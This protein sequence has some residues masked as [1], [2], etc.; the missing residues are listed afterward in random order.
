MAASPVC[1]DM[2]DYIVPLQTL[3]EQ[4]RRLPGVGSKTA[5]RYAMAV[6]KLGEEDVANFADAILGAKRDVHHCKTCF[7]ISEDDICPICADPDRDPTTI[8]VVEDIQDV[9]AVERVRNYRGLYH[10]LGGV[11]NPRRQISG[12][13]LHIAELLDRVETGGVSEVILATNPTFEG[14]TTAHYL[15]KLLGKYEGLRVTRLAYGIP[16]GGDLEY[17]DEITLERAMQ[18][19]NSLK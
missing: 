7:N 3:I 10:V 11:L 2:A 18:G 1:S 5:V 19:R 14:D 4:F 17:A 13:H 8:C 6:L 16:V 15:A 12:D 9:M